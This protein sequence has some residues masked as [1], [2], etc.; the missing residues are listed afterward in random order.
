MSHAIGSTKGR[1]ASR[2]LALACLALLAWPCASAAGFQ[3][4]HRYPPRS[5]SS[6]A[7]ASATAET[8][9]D[10][11]L[12]GLAQNG[13]VFIILP[14]GAG[15]ARCS[16]TSVNSPNLSLVITAGHC[17]YDEGQWLAHKWV[18]VPGYRYG[19][20]P[21]GTFT[22][23]W[24]GTTPQWLASENEN[25]DVGAAVV[26]R[27]ERGQRLAEAVGGYGIAWGLSP[28]QVFDVYGYPVAPPFNGA[29][30]QSCHQAPFE[31]HDFNSFLSPG[32]LDLAI[33]CNVTPGSSGGGWVTSG[34][35]LNSVTSSGY[36][37]DPT[38]EFGPYFGRAVAKLFARAARVR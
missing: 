9:P 5:P 22:A 35:F 11:T 28:K 16:G 6:E 36:G 10:P 14:H 4:P 33:P 31:G 21:F 13:A 29:T 24:L 3:S 17:V 8:V 26:S 2:L 19:E 25:F 1:R 7:L 34:G 15:A 32:P 23:H 37:D 20:R 30:L 38:T 12:P 27:N 18:F